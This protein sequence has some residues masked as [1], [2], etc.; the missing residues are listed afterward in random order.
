MGRTPSSFPVVSV[1]RYVGVSVEFAR[2]VRRPFRAWRERVAASAPVG[3]VRG[4]SW[5]RVRGDRSGLLSHA[6]LF[7]HLI[8]KC[9]NIVLAIYEQC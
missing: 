9:A 6:E 1:F 3:R 2:V 7:S 4:A 5:R 8:I